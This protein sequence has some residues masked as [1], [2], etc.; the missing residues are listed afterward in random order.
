MVAT[1]HQLPMEE[2]TVDM[3]VATFPMDMDDEQQQIRI[4]MFSAL[5]GKFNRFGQKN[6]DY[7]NKYCISQ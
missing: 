4:W 6:L 5:Y 1:T 2:D 7:R 3:L